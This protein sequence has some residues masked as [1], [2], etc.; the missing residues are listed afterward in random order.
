MWF[1]AGQAIK[2]ASKIICMGYS[3]P[4]SDLTMAQFLKSSAPTPHIPFEVVDVSSKYEHFS[5]VIGGEVYEFR[6]EGT[7]EDCI[8]K[9]VVKRCVPE[10]EDKTYVIRMTQWKNTHALG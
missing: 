8:P 10:Q 9:F 6:Q 2:K 5:N 3:L 4:M 1:Q 7:D